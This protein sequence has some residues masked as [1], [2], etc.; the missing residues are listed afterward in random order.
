MSAEKQGLF[1]TQWHEK[2]KSKHATCQWFTLHL[3][4]LVTK[5]MDFISLELNH[6]YLHLWLLVDQTAKVHDLHLDEISPF[7]L[8]LRDFKSQ[9]PI[10]DFTFPGKLYIQIRIFFWAWSSTAHPISPSPYKPLGDFRWMN[11]FRL[12][13][14]LPIHPNT[15]SFLPPVKVYHI[16][17]LIKLAGLWIKSLVTSRA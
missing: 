2:I 10:F 13:V 8:R 9:R 11:G 7:Y 16:C 6:A 5:Q 14:E 4:C 1:G 15:E 3:W 12:C 17:K